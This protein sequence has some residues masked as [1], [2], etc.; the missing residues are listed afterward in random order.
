M[1]PLHEL[2]AGIV[3]D[4]TQRRQVAG[5]GERV[6]DGH[7]V[8]GVREHVADEVRADEAG[9]AGDE[10]LHEWTAEKPGRMSSG[11][12]ER[13]GFAL[14]RPERIGCAR[15]SPVG[16]DL[17]VV[18]RHAELVVR[19]V[20]AVDEVRDRHVGERGESVRDAG[21]DVDAAVVVD[22]VGAHAAVD[23]ER[24]AVGRATRSAGRGAR[25]GPGRTA[26]TSSR[27]GSGGS[28]ARR[29]SRP[30]GR[31]GSSGSSRGHAGSTRAGTSRRT[32]PR[33]SP[34]TTGST[35]ITPAM[36][37]LSRRSPSST[38]GRLGSGRRA[39]G[40]LH[41]GASPDRTTSTSRPSSESW[42]RC[43]PW[44]RLRSSTSEFSISVSTSSQSDAIDVYG[45]DI[46]VDELASGRR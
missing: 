16:R 27:P 7:L 37:S 13:R 20:V 14:S 19:V 45:P 46:G 26:R 3:V 35:S 40:G 11:I 15:E 18:P 33:A 9:A 28:A 31:R 1:L 43:T 30:G 32:S 24:R 29:C 42:M 5:V 17:G 44:I 6:V 38:P 2:V 23:R 34:W 22:A 8:V 36:T 21:R 10:Q 41:A 25:R 39:S 12:S 4:V